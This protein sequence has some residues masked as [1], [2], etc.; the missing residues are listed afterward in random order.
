MR[1]CFEKKSFMSHISGKNGI[2]CDICYFDDEPDML[3]SYRRSISSTVSP[4]S[5]AILVIGRPLDFIALANSSIA[6]A[7]PFSN[8]KASPLRSPSSKPSSY[9][10]N[11]DISISSSL[12]NSLNS[13]STISVPYFFKN[14]GKIPESMHPLMSSVIRLAVSWSFSCKV[15]T[16]STKRL[17]CFSVS[18][19]FRISLFLSLLIVYTLTV[20]CKAISSSSPRNASDSFIS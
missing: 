18:H 15:L 3:S 16:L 6:L 11:L 12:V 13:I 10:S 8:P 1:H 5:A 7:R 4:V 14:S 17:Y 19:F 2:P 20:S 9:P